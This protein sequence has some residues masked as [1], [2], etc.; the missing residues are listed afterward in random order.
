MQAAAI[1]QKKRL[2]HGCAGRWITSVAILNC[3]KRS[4]ARRGFSD[5]IFGGGKSSSSSLDIPS[6]RD[7]SRRC[8]GGRLSRSVTVTKGS[9]NFRAELGVRS[10]T[11]A[12]CVLLGGLEARLGGIM[13]ALCS[14]LDERGPTIVPTCAFSITGVSVSI[15]ARGKSLMGVSWIGDGES[16]SS[17]VGDVNIAL[18][19]GCGES[20]SLSMA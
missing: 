10:T 9:C 18:R 11:A 13:T 15:E 6:P 17:A 5:N 8:I 12:S 20:L 3:P 7:S 1:W 16:S 4:V 2:C 19:G 14:P